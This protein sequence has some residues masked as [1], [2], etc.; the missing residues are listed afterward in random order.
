MFFDK[1]QYYTYQPT[2]PLVVMM[3]QQQ[4]EKGVFSE[5]THKENN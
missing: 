3:N 4:H 2:I 1:T 5:Q